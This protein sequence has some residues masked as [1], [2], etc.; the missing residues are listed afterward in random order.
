MPVQN[1]NSQISARPD[2]ATNLPHILLPTT[3]NSLLCQKMQFT[4]HLDV[5]EDGLL[6]KYLVIIP[7]PPPPPPPRSYILKF[8]IE[9]FACLKRSFSGNC[10]SKRQGSYTRL[11]LPKSLVPTHYSAINIKF[12]NTGISSWTFINLFELWDW[13]TILDN[14]KCVI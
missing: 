8:F 7:P 3:F 2:L 12:L 6:G 1:S 13:S 4:Q 11:V 10:L 9:N 14:V 5:L